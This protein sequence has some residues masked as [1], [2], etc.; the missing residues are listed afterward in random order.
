MERFNTQFPVPKP[1][2]TPTQKAKVRPI[3]SIA[4]ARAVRRAVTGLHRMRRSHSRPL[5]F[6]QPLHVVLI[7]CAWQ[8]AEGPMSL[9]RSFHARRIRVHITIRRSHGLRSVLSAYLCAF[10]KHWNL[11]LLDVDEEYTE[12]EW[13]ICGK[14]T[15]DTLRKQGVRFQLP[16]GRRGAKSSAAAAVAAAAAHAAAAASPAAP[17]APPL[18]ATPHPAH[19]RVEM[20]K[21][22]HVHQLYVRGDSVVSVCQFAPKLH[23]LPPGSS[24]STS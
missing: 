20:F 17:A 12:W 24:D 23:K 2:S 15:V 16:C 22:R 11:L 8:A 3:T 10:D 6:V 9:L 19:I 7:V 13:K 18:L 4:N 5:A 14:H 21:R 1:I